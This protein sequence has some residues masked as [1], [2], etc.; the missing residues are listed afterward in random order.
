LDF[1]IIAIARWGL[2]LSLATSCRSLIRSKT[3]RAR[4]MRSRVR[5]VAAP[6]SRRNAKS[7]ARAISVAAAL[8]ITARSSRNFCRRLP[9]RR[10]YD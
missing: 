3:Q 6:P 8:S 9:R 2:T 5:C 1:G 4:P 7:F 10:R